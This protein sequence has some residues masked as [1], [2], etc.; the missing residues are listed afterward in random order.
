MPWQDLCHLSLVVYSI[1]VDSG[2][3]K[4]ENKTQTWMKTNHL[5]LSFFYLFLYRTS[6]GLI[7]SFSYVQ[8]SK[9]SI[10][11]RIPKH[12]SPPNAD[13]N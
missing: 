2:K 1:S 4:S 8:M 3:K 9:K 7:P 11:A 6:S 12:R 13:S 10:L 5:C